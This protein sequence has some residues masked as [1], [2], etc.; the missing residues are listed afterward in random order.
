MIREI[1]RRSKSRKRTTRERSVRISSTKNN[2]HRRG[3]RVLSFVFYS[4]R[5]RWDWSKR[6]TNK[7]CWWKRKDLFDALTQS[8][9]AT[10]TAHAIGRKRKWKTGVLFSSSSF[11]IAI[12]LWTMN[13]L[14]WLQWRRRETISLSSVHVLRTSSN[15]IAI[16]KWSTLMQSSR[17]REETKAIHLLD[18]R[19]SSSTNKRR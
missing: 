2:K 13:A 17:S 12:E 4:R 19:L 14:I 6:N 5:T 8:T 10:T 7:R 18:I 1:P 9:R 3:V 16:E 15:R 11:R